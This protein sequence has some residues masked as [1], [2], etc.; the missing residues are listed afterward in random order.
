MAFTRTN[1]LHI[2]TASAA[3]VLTACGGGSSNTS[4]ASTATAS[5]SGTSS[6][7]TTT[8]GTAGTT[9]SATGTTTTGTTTA[10]TTPAA[11]SSTVTSTNE[12]TPLIPKA[13]D[14]LTYSNTMVSAGTTSAFTTVY[15]YSSG[16]YGGK[17]AVVLT[18]TSTVAGKTTAAVVYLDPVT[19][20]VL[21]NGNST[22]TTITSYD[23]ADYE[24][25]LRNAV[26]TVGQSATVNVKARISGADITTAF[27][28]IGGGTALNIDYTFTMVRMP[29]ETVTT[30]GSSYNTCKLK[31]DA[32]VN[33]VTLEG[34]N[35]SNPL[36]GLMFSTLSAVYAAPIN[37]TV[38]MSNQVPN[39]VKAT[40]SFTAMGSTATST[41]VL[42]AVKLAG[43]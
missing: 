22:E 41:T 43:R 18:E 28:T 12:C 14:S 31:V 1:A 36:Y 16:S 9:T 25:R 42:T 13:G 19:G 10:A 40:G 30:A 24:T 26:T 39:M 27:S 34:G 4:S 38:W 35:S 2:L 33:S 6:T 20:A 37:T 15:D 32:T 21:G 5:T 7:T 23:P 8:T 17:S 29:N 3:L 11:T